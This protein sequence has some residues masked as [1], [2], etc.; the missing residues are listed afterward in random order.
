MDGLV[1]HVFKKIHLAGLDQ[2]P[3]SFM[4]KDQQGKQLLI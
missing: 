2:C 1:R 4:C 3:S